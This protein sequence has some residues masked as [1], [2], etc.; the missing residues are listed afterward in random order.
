[1]KRDM[2]KVRTMLFEFSNGEGRT[3]FA[4]SLE[5]KEY[6]YHLEI[7]RQAGLINYKESKFKGGMSLL[8]VPELT[9][10][11]NDYLDAIS[12]EGIWNKTK[13][14]IRKK[15]IEVSNIPL[16]MVIDV[17]KMQLKSL[18]GLE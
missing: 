13:E 17:A 12:D 8:N 3:S 1:M 10:I 9:W 2:E 6:I 18:F 5:D 4:N 16:D 11:G 7:M 14:T 15:G